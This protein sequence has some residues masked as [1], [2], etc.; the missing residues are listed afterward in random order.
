[1]YEYET[2][3][4]WKKERLCHLSTGSGIS[5]DFSSPPEFKGL[6]G[7][8]TPEDL[9][10]AAENTCFLMTFISM[11]EKMRFEFVSYECEAVG[12]L[13]KTDEG[14]MFTRIVLRPR[15]V[16]ENEDDVKKVERALEV[17][18]KNCLIANSMKTRIIIEPEIIVGG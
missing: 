9:F 8:I 18:D 6:E 15:V 16:I 3:V 4:E 10:V 1:M 5:M 11:S 2:K 13:E 7:L 17:T 12:Y 14:Y